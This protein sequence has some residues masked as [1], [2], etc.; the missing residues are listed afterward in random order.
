MSAPA[1]DHK[2]ICEALLLCMML[3]GVID[4]QADREEIREI[5]HVV[6]TEPEFASLTPQDFQELFAQAQRNLHK[7]A[8]AIMLLIVRQ[9]TDEDLRRR[10]LEL[11]VRVITSDGLVRKSE[12]ALLK[13]LTEQLDLTQ[14]D[15][16]EIVVSSQLRLVRFM[17]VYLVYLSA[18]SDGQLSDREF[19][20]MIPLVL[21]QSVFAGIESDEFRRICESVQARFASMEEPKS[22]EHIVSTVLH[23]E[24]MLG[25]EGIPEQT[26]KIV[27]RGV[28]ADGSVDPDEE[29][30]FLELAKKF[31]LAPDLGQAVI[32]GA[33]SD[34]RER[35]GKL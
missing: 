7:G 24:K 3:T 15:L 11:A 30:F 17:I 26:L 19:E 23:A 22:V 27:A 33:V 21:C 20:E 10:G 34:S 6:Q 16:D 32:A 25:I 9:L 18:G 31:G 13:N 14:D 28:F 4:G 8:D 35:L 29:E 5:T 2:K 1:N 12:A